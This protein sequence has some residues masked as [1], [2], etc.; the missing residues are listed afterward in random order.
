MYPGSIDLHASYYRWNEKSEEY[1]RRSRQ[2]RQSLSWALRYALRGF[3]EDVWWSAAKGTLGAP[4]GSMAELLNPR[5]EPALRGDG[6]HSAEVVAGL[7]AEG[8]VLL[9]PRMHRVRRSGAL[10]SR[11][12]RARLAELEAQRARQDASPQLGLPLEEITEPH[13]VIELLENTDPDNL[14]PRQALALLYQLREKL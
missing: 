3:N 4:G 10:A 7:E 13:P 1:S 12:F 5:R 2:G 9:W 14:S 8:G 6:T 11:G